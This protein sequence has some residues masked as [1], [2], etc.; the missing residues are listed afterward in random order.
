VLEELRALFVTTYS[1]RVDAEFS[2]Y[3][4][5]FYV[6][7]CLSQLLASAIVSCYVRLHFP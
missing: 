3:T 2:G 4:E 7:F 5:V 1:V 6:L